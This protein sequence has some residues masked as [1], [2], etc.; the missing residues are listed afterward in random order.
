MKSLNL[1]KWRFYA[2]L[3]ASLMAFLLAACTFDTSVLD[4]RRCSTSLE[5]EGGALC[6]EGI[7]QV[8]PE[9]GQ[10]DTGDAGD[11]TDEVEPCVDFDND[12]FRAGDD[13]EDDLIDCNDFDPHVFPG[14]PEVC[15]GLDN[16]CDTTTDTE[17]LNYLPSPCALVDGICAGTVQ[18]C[19]DGV[20]QACTPATY[21]ANY[22]LD[23]EA[24]ERADL[25]CD[26][27]DNDCDGFVDENLQRDCFF[28]DCAELECTIDCGSGLMCPGGFTCNTDDGYCQP[29][30]LPCTNGIELCDATAGDWSG[31]CSGQVAAQSE[32]TVFNRCDD[33]DNDCDGELDELCTCQPGEV[34]ICYSLGIACDGTT[35]TC[36]DGFTCNVEMARCEPEHLPCQMGVRTCGDDA[37][38][39]AECVGEVLPGIEE[40][41]TVEGETCGN[42]G[43]D[44]D[45]D[46]DFTTAD[47]PGWGPDFTCS[48]DSENGQC[49]AGT[50]LCD[51]DTLTCIS[52]LGP[53]PETC[54]NRNQDN[55]CDGTGSGGDGDI[56]GLLD[57]CYIETF[58]TLPIYGICRFGTLQCWTC[59]VLTEE[60]DCP[61]DMTCIG[62]Y[63]GMACTIDD[64]C[65]E[66]GDDCVDG[67]CQNDLVCRPGPRMQDN[68]S[69]LDTTDETCNGNPSCHI[70][71]CNEFDDDCDNTV[72]E[73]LEVST[74]DDEANCGACGN[75]CGVDDTCCEGGCVD[76]D[77][78]TT[79]VDPTEPDDLN[80][81]GSCGNSC[82]EDFDY[83]D[84]ACCGGTCVDLDFNNTHCSACGSGCSGGTATCCDGVCRNVLGT[85]YLAEDPAMLHCGACDQPC[86]FGIEHCV[87]GVCTPLSDEDHCGTSNTDCTAGTQDCCDD[88]DTGP[89]DYSCET[90]DDSPYCGACGVDCDEDGHLVTPDCCE[91]ACTD[92]NSDMAN[93]SSCGNNCTT[94][95]AANDAC[96]SGSCTDLDHTITRC[97][98]CD[99]NCNNETYLEPTPNPGCHD[100][101]CTD[102]NWD[103]D[104]CGAT[105]EDCSGDD[106]A[107]CS[108]ACEDLDENDA[109]CGE[110]DNAC[111]GDERCCGGSCV[112]KDDINN[113]GSCGNGCVVASGERC[114]DDGGSS[115]TCVVSPNGTD[116]PVG[117]LTYGGST[118]NESGANNGTITDTLSITLEGDTFTVTSDT[119]PSDRYSTSNVPAGLT[120]VIT[121][122][123]TG[124]IATL[125]LSGTAQ[126][127]TNLH[128]VSNLTVEFLNA[129]F[130]GGDADVITNYRTTNLAV[131]FDDPD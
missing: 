60:T 54:H 52:D 6:V 108:G 25:C 87:A 94:L 2:W 15:D 11:M 19:D 114:C 47:I 118:F 27:F 58:E 41:P 115:F 75:A 86:R 125:Q 40:V 30:T 3:A 110:C 117:S 8:I 91:S 102:R 59:T 119:L 90:L 116:C 61:G 83:F 78:T 120:P 85:G 128:D 1:R 129:A 7:C 122:N 53:V 109:H 42:P 97:G 131:D 26:G 45:C 35:V 99:T 106:D 71:L 24:C 23:E 57:P 50:M 121:V 44:N 76:V 48:V 34:R 88:V 112:D 64:E 28:V 29:S 69:Y 10:E 17:D 67:V 14:A 63:C 37:R 89:V 123:G 46:G 51:D 20:P 9:V 113:C 38:F 84:P 12:T 82:T 49:V 16:D 100:G 72:D 22:V 96:C 18:E 55:D 39:G 33:I 101:S 81:C 107:C 93:C 74:N 36:P 77:R 73:A 21:G 68:V 62:G 56:E 127:H 32:D 124:L 31:V 104:F 5:C 126:G 13:C 4:A 103:V 70:E 105:E 65:D 66:F 43:I 92:L 111:A 95:D 130:T 79:P 80:H 98:D